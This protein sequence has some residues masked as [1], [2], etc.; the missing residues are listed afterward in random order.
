MK[1]RRSGGTGAEAD[2]CNRA[3][4]AR[5]TSGVPCARCRPHPLPSPARPAAYRAVKRL[6]GRMRPLFPSNIEPVPTANS[7]VGCHPRVRLHAGC[8]RRAIQHGRGSCQRAARHREPGAPLICSVADR[9]NYPR[10]AD[11]SR[12]PHPL[13]RLGA[14]AR[15]FAD[16]DAFAQRAYPRSADSTSEVRPPPA[17]CGCGSRCAPPPRRGTAAGLGPP[18]AA[19]RENLT[20]AGLRR[21]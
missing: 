1:C 4:L 21:R 8:A 6:Q 11:Q 7:P 10:S 3:A 12:T 16:A 19:G 20:S 2:A 14:R 13:A 9:P 18:M 15:S 5:R 17:R